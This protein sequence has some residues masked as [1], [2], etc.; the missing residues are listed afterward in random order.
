MD[1]IE[2][3]E[4]LKVATETLRESADI[5]QAQRTSLPDRTD[6]TYEIGASDEAALSG[7]GRDGGTE[8]ESAD[9][10]GRAD[11][12]HPQPSRGSNPQRTDLQLEESEL[13]DSIADET[14]VR[15]NLPTVEEHLVRGA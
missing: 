9:A 2:F 14:E 8:R 11:E 1:G 4:L 7:A 12:Q 15:A 10:V 6:S 3:K 5:G 13:Q